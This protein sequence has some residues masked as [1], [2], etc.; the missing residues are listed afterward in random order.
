MSDLEF[1]AARQRARAVGLQGGRRVLALH[2][3]EIG[4][5]DGDHAHLGHEV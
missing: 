4:A 1:E 2:E 5:D 3:L